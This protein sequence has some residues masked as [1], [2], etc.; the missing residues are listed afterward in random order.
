MTTICKDGQSDA[1][2]TEWLRQ[3]SVH[4]SA[5]GTADIVHC[6]KFSP[7][8]S[9]VTGFHGNTFGTSIRVAVLWQKT[10]R[11]NLPRLAEIE[12]DPLRIND[13]LL[14]MP[15]RLLR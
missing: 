10:D 3:G 14:S 6:E 11:A 5:W 15:T 4:P 8:Q 2:R 9:V 12:G 7:C 1:L 13:W